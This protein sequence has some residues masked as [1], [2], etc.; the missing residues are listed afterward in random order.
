[1]CGIAA[2][3]NQAGI[4]TEEL[5]KA[6]A[7]LDA[8]RHRGPD[9]E[10]AVLIQSSTGKSWTL[11]L[12]DTPADLHCDLHPEEYV[13][14]TADLI[15]M[16]R[17]LSIFDLSSA[18]HQPMRDAAGN[19]ILL[20]GEIYNFIEIRAELEGLGHKFHTRTDTEVV[21]AA[22][23][24]WGEACLQKFNGMWAIILY[25]AKAHRLMVTVDRFGVKMLYTAQEGTRRAYASEVKSFLRFGLGVDI[26][27]HENLS[28]FLQF[29]IIDF[30]D[31]TMFPKI[32]RVQPSHYHFFDLHQAQAATPQRYWHMPPAQERPMSEK[33]AIAAFK[34]HFHNSLQLRLRT[35]VPWGVTLSGGLDSSAIIY[36]V[37]RMQAAK[38]DNTPIQTFS[39]VFP[40]SPAD[41]GKYVH[42]IEK[43]LKLD[44]RYVEPLKKF[45]FEDFERF[46]YH[47]DFPVNS[48]SSYARWTVFQLVAESN[49][50]VI[51][52]GQGGDEILGG[53]HHHF[54]RFAGEMLRKFRWGLAFKEIRANAKIQEKAFQPF[55]KKIVS[56]EIL[57]RSRH[58]HHAVGRTLRERLETDLT[59]L[60]IP[61]MLRYEDRISMAFGIESRVPFLDYRLVEFGLQLPSTLKIHQGWQKYILRKSMDR[62]PREIAWRKDKKGFTTPQGEWVKQYRDPFMGYIDQ[63]EK[64]NIPVNRE[65]LTRETDFSTRNPKQFRYLAVGAWLKTF[66]Y[67]P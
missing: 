34:E 56:A 49:V 30:D 2:Y 58:S 61:Y 46:V 17:R 40:G 9:G 39:A 1:M 31:S 62:A 7:G 43:D 41:E 26:L 67:K 8:I 24:Q 66:Q 23:Q 37:A 22:Y 38:G 42:L 60:M 44:A 20:N 5:H 3:Y 6:L 50:K 48:T 13:A 25:D 57:G 52:N 32:T 65:A 14:G 64:A 45:N 33:A 27:H 16:H 11:R 21:M 53:Y 29:G 19:W 59:Q 54:Q 4:G 18:G 15:F 55:L 51:L 47:Q 10:G 28:H 63:L 35:D 12:P 36:E